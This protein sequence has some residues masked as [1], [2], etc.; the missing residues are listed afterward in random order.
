MTPTLYHSPFACSLASRFALG[1]ADL[2]HELHVVRLSAGENQKADYLAINPRKKVPALSTG[3]GLL[4]ETSAIL[5]YIADQVPDK[6]L[7]PPSGSFARAQAQSWLA[8]LSGTL[9]PCFTG[10]FRPALFTTD[11]A[12]H[13]SVVEAHTARMVIAFEELEARLS[14]QDFLLGQFS[15]CDVYLLVFLTWRGGPAMAGKLPPFPSLD[16][17]QARLL[18]RPVLSATLQ[19]DMRLL[20]GGSPF[21]KTRS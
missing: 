12:G 13:N 3:D 8:F 17:Y 1:E 18:S 14:Q 10:V 19:D 7:L 15:L 6:N 9:H 4:T 21:T 5:P 16:A 11:E 20:A 2:D